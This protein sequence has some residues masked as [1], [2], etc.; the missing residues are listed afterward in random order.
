MVVKPIINFATKY[1][2]D[3]LGLSVRK[4]TKP[5]SFE[6]LRF[7]PRNTGDVFNTSYAQDYLSADF[8]KNLL[9]IKG[10]TQIETAAKIKDEILT[11]MKYKNPSALQIIENPLTRGTGAFCPTTG[12]ITFSQIP[13][14]KEDL[15]AM[16]YHE[17]DHMDKIVKIYKAKGAESFEALLKTNLN[18]SKLRKLKRNNDFYATMSKDISIDNFNVN[19]YARALSKYR[20]FNLDEL[21]GQFLYFHNP[22][23]KDAY[24]IQKKY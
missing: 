21:Y 12:K 9:N 23:E 8:I 4:W 22:L 10:K 11:A 5:R 16:L 18:K 15:I 1:T 6:N 14:S 13:E 19:R 2:D 24:A 17:L 3:I 7:A 20:N